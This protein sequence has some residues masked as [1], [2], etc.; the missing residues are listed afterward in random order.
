MYSAFSFR[1]RQQLQGAQGNHGRH[2]KQRYISPLSTSCLPCMSIVPPCLECHIHIRKL[3]MYVPTYMHT[4]IYCHLPL[5]SPFPP[6][7]P[8][9]GVLLPPGHQLQPHW[10]DIRELGSME[11]GHIIAMTVPLEK[12]LTLHYIKSTCAYHDV[13]IY[14]TTCTEMC[15][16]CKLLLQTWSTN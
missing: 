7:S 14:I 15:T 3:I 10:R 6:P 5:P 9:S 1:T 13:C 4:Y 11:L 2:H 16:A 12:K 8:S